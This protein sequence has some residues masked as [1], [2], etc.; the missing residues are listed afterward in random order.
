MSLRVFQVWF[1]QTIV[2]F[3]FRVGFDIAFLKFQARC[4]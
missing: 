4:R 3:W 1:S 2:S